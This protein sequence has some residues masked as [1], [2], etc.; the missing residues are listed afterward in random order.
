MT[1]G[2]PRACRR[3]AWSVLCAGVL[4][5]PPIQAGVHLEEIGSFDFPTATAAVVVAGD[6]AVTLSELGLEIHD[7]SDPSHPQRVGSV[8]LH[9]PWCPYILYGYGCPPNPYGLDAA[10]HYAYVADS[11][12]LHIVDFGDPRAPMQ[13]AL[14][15]MPQVYAGDIR[16]ANGIAY[17]AAGS[18]ELR[19]VDVSDPH[20]PVEI[21][22]LALS[23][24]GFD[25]VR[26]GG[27][28]V[29]GSLIYVTG[30]GTMGDFDGY[31]M[32]WIIDAS[33]PS[34]PV[35]R[36][37]SNMQVSWPLAVWNGFAYS[38]RGW[39]ADGD[40]QVI[41]VSDPT[42]P[43]LGNIV[44]LPATVSSIAVS[45]GL[46]YVSLQ[47]PVLSNLSLGG[48]V[49]LDLSTPAAPVV[50]GTLDI[51]AQNAFLRVAAADGVAVATSG[52]GIATVDA[53]SPSQP[54]R[55]ADDDPH[56]DASGVRVVG[57]LAFVA[58]EGPRLR[59][60]DVSDPRAPVEVAHLDLSGPTPPSQI[61]WK[62]DGIEIAGNLAYLGGTYGGGVRIVDISNP[63][64]PVAVGTIP[65]QGIASSISL[66]G[67][68]AYVAEAFLTADPPGVHIV[69]VTDPSA[70]AE[71]GFYP[72]ESYNLEARGTLVY[73]LEPDGLHVLDASDPTQLTEIGSFPTA[74]LAQ[75]GWQFDRLALDGSRAFLAG[76]TT[77]GGPGPTLLVD[78]DVSAPNQPVERGRVNGAP[79][80]GVAD[81]TFLDLKVS[82]TEVF[83]FSSE[84]TAWDV[85]D[86]A[87]PRLDDQVFFQPYSADFGAG[88]I[89]PI[90]DLIYVAQ[91]T[92]GLRIFRAPEPE[93][94][95]LALAACGVLAFLAWCRI[96]G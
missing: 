71:L 36:S 64:A 22:S 66:S 72:V 18:A 51:T 4:A 3:L 68:R 45:A 23:T 43:L 17:V 30:S 81:L 60:F 55:L 31:P 52:G 46:A 87:A 1:A 40:V 63:T 67:N 19:F 93:N 39:W 83:A 26:A 78:L 16:V 10:G 29:A 54:V 14:L 61:D 50:A 56:D 57:T 73:L 11:D 53:S 12:G 15:A 9:P 86:P 33:N 24:P 42:A 37:A 79:L 94:A 44:S 28:A 96:D 76:H 85:S 48:L 32:L 8:A 41:D 34:A 75:D 89:D 74:P 47:Q 27:L 84:L 62:A 69:D 5:A 90:G 25:E 80:E 91:G 77:S 38:G 35:Q 92:A 6:F 70:P 58:Y 49:V 13:T 2:R 82:G 20:A 21:G 88:G 95:L 59:V 65:L 7:I